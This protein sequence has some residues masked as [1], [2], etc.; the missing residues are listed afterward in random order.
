MIKM[1]LLVIQTLDQARNYP[2]SKQQVCYKLK[3]TLSTHF[4]F[5][6]RVFFLLC[7]DC[8]TSELFSCRQH[9]STS[10]QLLR[11][12]PAYG[13][14]AYGDHITFVHAYSIIHK[15]QR[16]LVFLGRF[17]HGGHPIVCVFPFF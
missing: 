8:S 9:P 1:H 6:V 15:I 12:T 10:C 5:T 16:P 4:C 14:R 7:A 3:V 17:R 13:H 2:C 11:I